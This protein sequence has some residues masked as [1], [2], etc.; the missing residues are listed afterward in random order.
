MLGQDPARLPEFE[1]A[2]IKPVSPS[3][4]HRNG[5]KV[6]PGGEI[7]IGSVTLKTLVCIAYGVGWWQV[8]GGDGWVDKDSYD[9]VAKPPESWASKITDLRYSLFGIDDENLRQM[10]Q[11]L[12]RGRF[13][14]KVHQETKR[15]RV[16]LLELNGRPL[17]LKPAPPG[18]SAKAS[19]GSVDG[20]ASIG[21]A[22]SWVISHTTMQQLAKFASDFYIHAP[23]L[24]RTGLDGVFEYRSPEEAPED[25]DHI[26]S[27]SADSFLELLHSV[28]LKLESSPGSVETLVIDHAERP[29]PN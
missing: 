12:L 6:L 5:V 10:L 19:S 11:A 21:F 27:D 13:Q 3:G 25:S 9:V 4:M 22:G 23:V 2:T 29:S 15:G 8:S 20:F 14:L 16:Y 17:K 1:V 26:V 7:D 24:D 18:P 28:G